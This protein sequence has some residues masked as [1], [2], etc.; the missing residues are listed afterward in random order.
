[1]IPLFLDHFTF[2]YKIIQYYSLEGIHKN[3]AG[4][5]NKLKY[6]RLSE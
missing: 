6:C 4:E 2:F 3:S 5:R 1:M